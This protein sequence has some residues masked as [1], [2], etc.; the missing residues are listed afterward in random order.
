MK[1][2]ESELKNI[3]KKADESQSLIPRERAP[4]RRE[5]YGFKKGDLGNSREVS[6]SFLLTEEEKARLDMKSKM[7]RVS[8]STL[9]WGFLR[10]NG[11]YDLPE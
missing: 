4:Q 5:D 11:F 3:W 9:V 7:L 10:E 2:E 6:F 1:V 8:R